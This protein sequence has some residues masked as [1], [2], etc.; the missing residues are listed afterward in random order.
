MKHFIGLLIL[1][2]S[3]IYSG[4]ETYES[5]VRAGALEALVVQDQGRLKPFDTFARSQLLVFRGRSSID[6]QSATDWL[7]E[8]MIA[9]EKAFERKVFKVVEKEAILAL[10]IGLDPDYL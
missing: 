1:L 3:G 9:P 5:P 10:G 4:A 2:S 7:L 8:L 6:R